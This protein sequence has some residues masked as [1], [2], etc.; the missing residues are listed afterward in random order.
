[1]ASFFKDKERNIL[2]FLFTGLASYR[3]LKTVRTHLASLVLPWS[4]DF[5]ENKE[6]GLTKEIWESMKK[7]G[8]VINLH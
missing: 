3:H 8:L 4:G 6:Q 1:M 2:L 7:K 5:N